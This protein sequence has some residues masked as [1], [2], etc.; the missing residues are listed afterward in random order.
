MTDTKQAQNGAMTP[1]LLITLGGSLLFTW[2]WN[3]RK[4]ATTLHGVVAEA[5]TGLPI[6]N[7]L[8][9][10]D[11]YGAYTAADGKYKFTSIKAGTYSGAVEHSGY[12]TVQ[13]QITIAA[14]D[15]LMDIQL[16]QV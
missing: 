7:A 11:G 12:E 2:W 10:L 5:G 14:G 3:H 6:A 15:N 16:T 4:K 13:F 1:L 9:S 8:I